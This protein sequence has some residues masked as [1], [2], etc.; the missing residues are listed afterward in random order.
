[1]TTEQF[2]N[3]FD[4]LLNSY[5]TNWAFGEDMSKAD[6]RLDIYE[7]SLFL[8][9]AQEELVV[10]LYTGRNSSG[11][12]FD[13]TEE[14]RRY[15]SPLVKEESLDPE[16]TDIPT[17]VAAMS[18]ADSYFFTLPET[19]WYIV[20]E[21]AVVSSNDTCINGKELDVVP[22]TH[23]EYNRV[24]RN[25]FRGPN[26]RKVLRLDVSEGTAQL[27]EIVSKYKVTSYRLRYLE[28]PTPIVLGNLDGL[29]INGETTTTECQLPT[30]LHRRILEIAVI[31]AL[32]SRNPRMQSNN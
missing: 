14:L 4:T 11:N 3:E 18:D 17:G 20:Y 23:D 31:K 19:A 15:L 22:V 12:S 1:M 5:A 29:E 13:E 25:P 8:T 32:Q 26:G 16:S 27:I 7:K 6:I 28:R 24:R 30:S 9:E 2:N 21:T 10:S